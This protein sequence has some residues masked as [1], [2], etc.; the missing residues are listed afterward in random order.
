[1]H[2]YRTASLDE[3]PRKRSRRLVSG[4]LVRVVTATEH[5]SI[6]VV[7]RATEVGTIAM[8]LGTVY[9]VTFADDGSALFVPD[10][11]RRIAG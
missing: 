2:P 11:L 8:V 7:R 4:D 6:A 1:M 5:S 9:L 10:E 3:R